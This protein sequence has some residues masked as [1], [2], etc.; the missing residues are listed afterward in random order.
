MLEI[1][2]ETKVV[3]IKLCLPNRG[4]NK[5]T[6]KQVHGYLNLLIHLNILTLEFFIDNR[7]N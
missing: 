2:R 6:I 4:R 5:I 3:K 7:L 1:L